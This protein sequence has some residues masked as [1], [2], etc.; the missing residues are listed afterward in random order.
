ME[1]RY[2]W[3][4]LDITCSPVEVQVQVFDLSIICELLIHVLFCRLFMYVRHEDY[5]S[6]YR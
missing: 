2:R 6:F 3:T 1:G 5:P 4:H